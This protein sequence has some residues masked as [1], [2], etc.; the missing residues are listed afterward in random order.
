MMSLAALAEGSLSTEDPAG[1]STQPPIVHLA[2]CGDCNHWVPW[3]FLKKVIHVL[4]V[5][6]LFD[7]CL[8]TSTSVGCHGSGT[9]SSLGSGMKASTAVPCHCW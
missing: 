7:A 2:V 6:E 3:I 4:I 5:F 1:R 9:M 8:K